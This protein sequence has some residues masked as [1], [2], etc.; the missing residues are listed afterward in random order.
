M[1]KKT[2]YSTLEQEDERQAICIGAA[3]PRYPDNSAAS[4]KPHFYFSLLKKATVYTQV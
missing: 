4:G 2:L 1:V 3:R